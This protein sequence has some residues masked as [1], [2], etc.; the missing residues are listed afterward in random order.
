CV[1]G[2]KC[3]ERVWHSEKSTPTRGIRSSVPADCTV[4]AGRL[5]DLRPWRVR[6]RALGHL[7][8]VGALPR[9]ARDR[10]AGDLD[11]GTPGGYPWPPSPLTLIRPS[12]RAPRRS[13]GFGQEWKP[14]ARLCGSDADR[15]TL[16]RI[17]TTSH[18]RKGRFV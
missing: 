16:R 17:V 1:K 7:R 15:N 6:S 3:W 12:T 4:A 2:G 14:P 10:V 5:R 18:P 11:R 9:F 8:R 13:A